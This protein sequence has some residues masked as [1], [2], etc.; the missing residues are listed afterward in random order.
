MSVLGTS[1]SPTFTA[2]FANIIA[3]YKFNQNT[4][5]DFIPR[6]N[7]KFTDYTYT[8][9]IDTDGYTIRT[10][11]NDSGDLP[12]LIRFGSS[13][14]GLTSTQASSL[15]S[16]EYIDTSKVTDMSYMFRHCSSLTSLDL[17]N[18]DT[19]N[20]T[21]MASMFYY[22]SKLT[23]LN[24][25]NFNTGQVTT[26]VSMFYNCSLLTSLDLSNWNTS[27][28]NNMGY[29][30]QS[31]ES[32]ASL[33]LSSFNTSKV[34]NMTGMFSSCSLLASL[35]L[36]SF[37]TSKLTSMSSMFS[38][39]SSLT[40]LDLSNF[41]TSQV[42]NMSYIFSGC[43]KLNSLDL[44]NFDTS[45]VTNTNSM[46]NAW[47]SSQE[48]HIS[49]RWTLGTS[50][51]PTFIATFART[52]AKYKFNQNT[53]ADFIPEFNT[54]FTDYVCNDEIDTDGYTI[55]T[56][57]ND[58]GELPTLIRFGYISGGITIAQAGSLLSVE[59]INTSNVND[60]S[61]MFYGCSKLTSLNLSN[62]DT[63]EVT[64][65]GSMFFGCSSLTSLDLSNFNTSNVI[66]FTNI[67]A[68]TSKLTNIGLLYALASTI[69]SL[70][71]NMG[72]DI[73][74]I[75]WYQDADATELN[76][77][78]N[79]ETK[80]YKTNILSCN[81][82]VILRSNGNVYDELN[83]LTGKLTQ[84]IDEDGVILTSEVIKT[85]NL[86]SN[87][88]RAYNGTTHYTCSS[89][90]DWLLPTVCIEVPIEEVK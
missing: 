25:S 43:S 3:K 1:F 61:N 75:I 36:S 73:A 14:G 45:Q 32:L 65:M 19:S 60:M 26:M 81:E 69:N 76:S 46:F 77:V 42:T 85:V 64:S 17:S 67:F 33:D 29:M 51:A 41:N 7:S 11:G 9:E 79:I 83:L 57:G 24:L 70:S 27:Q 2:T 84:R 13:A 48:V 47:S 78:T 39:C 5:A 34:T 22:C 74:R 62:W 54:G 58:S 49:S 20:V 53:Y 89:E 4:Y 44:S 23:S 31:C 40:S 90:E 12:T 56:I 37:D 86:S 6:F 52:I 21:T 16:V 87:V 59:Y 10:I 55:R 63:S 50:F 88:V 80:L 8:D 72:T 66:D 82:E 71:S 30:F 35:D 18:F 28:V 15:L 38:A 68:N